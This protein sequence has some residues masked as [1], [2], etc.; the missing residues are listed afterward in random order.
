MKRVLVLLALTCFASFAFAQRQLEEAELFC[1]ERVSGDTQ[2]AQWGLQLRDD[3]LRQCKGKNLKVCSKPWVDLIDKKKQGEIAYII[4]RTSQQNTRPGVRTEV[5]LATKQHYLAALEALATG[6]S[7][8]KISNDLYQMCFSSKTSSGGTAANQHP[9]A[10]AATSA[11]TNYSILGQNGNTQ[12]CQNC[13]WGPNNC[14]V[15]CY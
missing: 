9:P 6:E 5:I 8:Q 13:C 12:Y 3:M 4:D 10:S 14:N 2:K 7:P 15:T 1:G 11:C